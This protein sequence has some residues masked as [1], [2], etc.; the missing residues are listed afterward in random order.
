MLMAM[1]LRVHVPY[2]NSEPPA[3][4]IHPPS[5]HTVTTN[6]TVQLVCVA[7]GIPVPA[8][9]WSRPG[10]SNISSTLVGTGGIN[11][12]SESVKVQNTSFQK[13]ILQM[14][15]FELKDASTYTCSASNGISGNGIAGSSFSTSVSVLLPGLKIL[16]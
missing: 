12:F 4:V 15:N 7:Y 9:T 5:N 11:I 3:I 2:F 8:I 10:C 6:T 13:S 1:Y 14:C 16:L